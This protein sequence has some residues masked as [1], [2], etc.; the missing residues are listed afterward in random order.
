MSPK[1]VE[2]LSITWIY[3]IINMFITRCLIYCLTFVL[4]SKWLEYRFNRNYG[5][6]FFD[7]SYHGRYAHDSN[8]NSAI[9]VKSTDRG[10]YIPSILSKI[11]VV[12]TDQFPNVFTFSTWLSSTDA[13]AS[14]FYYKD[15]ID[16]IVIGRG[17]GEDRI[18]LYLNTVAYLGDPWTFLPSI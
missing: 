1:N 15:S 2:L 9:K 12:S 11:Q 13:F 5:E 4:A 18:R 14:I 8:T 7:Y 17:S 3:I 6:Y 16:S 10:V